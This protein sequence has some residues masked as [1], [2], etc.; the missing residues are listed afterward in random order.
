MTLNR[1][2]NIGFTL[3]ELMVVIVIFSLIA[4]IAVQRM[5]SLDNRWLQGE[6]AA[7]G[8]RLNHALDHALM[9]QEEIVWHHDGASNSYRFMV[10][11]VGN[12]WRDSSTK[13]L[14]VHL[15]TR[16]VQFRLTGK[17]QLANDGIGTL[18]FYP[19]GEYTPF[20]LEMTAAGSPGYTLSGDGFND[21]RLTVLTP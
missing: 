8:L 7:L 16:P 19:G 13:G 10:R 2:H 15:L 9:S 21:I 18:A 5:A 12:E 4:G 17:N 3:I 14:G 20:T 1:G 6:A 11:A